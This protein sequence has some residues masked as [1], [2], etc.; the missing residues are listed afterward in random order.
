MSI[1]GAADELQ[2]ALERR[3]AFMDEDPWADSA[4][5]RARLAELDREIRHQAGQ[6]LAEIKVA[7]PAGTAV[8]S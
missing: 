3:E 6:L 5:W 4:G 1:Q 7:A 2:A 8:Q